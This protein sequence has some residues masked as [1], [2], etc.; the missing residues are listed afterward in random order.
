MK[1]QK[2]YGIEETERNDKQVKQVYKHKS[3]NKQN[4]HWKKQVQMYK[5]S[6]S[7]RGENIDADI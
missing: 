7:Y 5:T 2:F 4:K 3:S 6:Y 1:P